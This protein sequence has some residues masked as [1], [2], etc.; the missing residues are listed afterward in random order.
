K[1][2]EAEPRSPSRKWASCRPGTSDSQDFLSF[3][4]NPGSPDSH[5]VKAV[6]SDRKSSFPDLPVDEIH[7]NDLDKVQE[8]GSLPELPSPLKIGLLPWGDADLMYQ[9]GSPPKA[10]TPGS[11][12]TRS[13]LNF[14]SGS[15]GSARYGR[16]ERI[17]VGFSRKQITCGINPGLDSVFMTGFLNDNP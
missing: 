6:Q 13:L 5:R 4:E 14:P 2:T 10:M 11:V 16:Q 15:E 8:N 17:N 7:C 1:R 12:S 3:E 9:A